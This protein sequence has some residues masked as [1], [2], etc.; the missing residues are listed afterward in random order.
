MAA[1]LTIPV[2]KNNTITATSSSTVYGGGIYNASNGTLRVSGS[3]ITG[4][5]ISS[6]YAYSSRNAFGGGIYNQ[7][8]LEVTNSTISN[9]SATDTLTQ[10]S[11]TV[12]GGGIYSTG[13]LTLRNNW[14]VGNSAT[15]TGNGSA[16]GGGIFITGTNAKKIINCEIAGNSVTGTN[17]SAGGI[18]ISTTT[19][20]SNMV[21]LTQSTIAGNFG[22]GIGLESGTVTIYNSIVAKN[23]SLDFVSGGNFSGL[24]G[25]YNLIGNGTGQN[26]LKNGVNG[27]IVG[28]SASLKDPGF[29]RI[30]PTINASTTGTNYNAENWRLQL[31]TNLLASENAIDRHNW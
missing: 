22:G 24:S 12:R 23:Q 17:S 20:N 25:Q 2:I 6:T 15:V 3:T 21:T 30:P 19:D 1:G 9:N 26:E 13:T 4:N 18:Y 10:N 27:N 29:D 5:S 31:S 8:T 11:S 28:A 16:Q 14:I 7:G